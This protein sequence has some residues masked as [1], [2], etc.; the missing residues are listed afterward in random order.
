VGAPARRQC[1]YLGVRFVLV[2]AALAVWAAFWAPASG[3]LRALRRRRSLGF[4][5]RLAHEIVVPAGPDGRPGQ[6]LLAPSRSPYVGVVAADGSRSDCSVLLGPNGSAL[7]VV[8]LGRVDEKGTPEQS[9]MRAISSVQDRA[10]QL[11]RLDES[12]VIAGRPA[13]RYLIE[14]NSGRRLLEWKF[15]YDGWLYAV[16]AVLH[17]KDDAERAEELGRS[18]LST[19]SWLEPAGHRDL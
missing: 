19:W 4:S 1:R 17:P 13:Q 6:R 12:D 18:V 5:N 14:L 2:V 16:G 11:R 7:L 3:P 9:A 8:C 10:G 15:D